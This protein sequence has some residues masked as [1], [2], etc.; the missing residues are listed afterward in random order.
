MKGF[1]IG[2]A[3]ANF[4]GRKAGFYYHLG[5][6]YAYFFHLERTVCLHHIYLIAHLNGTV[7]DTQINN[8]AAIFIIY[9]IEDQGS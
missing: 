2:N 9:R 5:L 3:V 1:D 4:P 7:E 6:K 8:D